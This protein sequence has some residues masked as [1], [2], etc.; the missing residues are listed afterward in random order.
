MITAYVRALG[1]LFDPRIIRLIGMSVLLSLLVFAGLWSAITWL[2]NNS[3][4]SETAG[5]EQVFDWFGQ[6]ATIVSAFFLFPVAISLLIGLFLDSVARAVEARHY[7]DLPKAKGVGLFAGLMATLRFLGKAV[8]LNV[9]LLVFLL[10]P[11]LTPIYP[12]AWTA[13]HAYLLG[14]EYFE[15]V[16]LRRLDV[17]ATFVLRRRHRL[18]IVAGGLAAVV[19][20]ALPVVNLIAPIVVTMAMVHALERWRHTPAA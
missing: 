4:L 20:F 2:L 16:A 13:A 18:Q 12:F 14:R 19:M 8:L 3:K 9:L 10:V 6:I 7:P 17:H 11:L 5:L 15:M 1:Q